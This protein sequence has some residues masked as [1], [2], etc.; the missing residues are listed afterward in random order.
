MPLPASFSEMVEYSDLKFEFFVCTRMFRNGVF[1]QALVAAQMK[2]GA[3]K[4][5]SKRPWEENDLSSLAKAIVK[6]PAGSQ[7]RACVSFIFGFAHLCFLSSVMFV[8]V[9][10][11]R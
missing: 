3:D 6:F 7:N 4:E 2:R 11:L 8:P 10:L 1:V 9:M 5:S